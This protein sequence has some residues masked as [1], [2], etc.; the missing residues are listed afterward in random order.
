MSRITD[1]D[2]LA[3]ITAM[4]VA[5]GHRASAR[6]IRAAMIAFLENPPQSAVDAAAYAQVIP[7]V[8][9]NVTRTQLR[10]IAS[11]LKEPS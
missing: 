5:G 1:L 8:A 9:G 6:A 10:A 11:A 4:E 7:D 2:L 3:S